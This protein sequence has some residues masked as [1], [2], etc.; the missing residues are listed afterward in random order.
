[1]CGLH[2]WITLKAIIVS[3]CHADHTH[4]ISI[5]DDDVFRVVQVPVQ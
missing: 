5:G 2:K 3:S 1:M 4:S